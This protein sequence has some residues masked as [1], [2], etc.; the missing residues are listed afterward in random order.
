VM[1]S[2]STYTF[3]LKHIFLIPAVLS[4]SIGLKGYLVENSVEVNG[5]LT[6]LDIYDLA[7]ALCIGLLFLLFWMMIKDHVVAVKL[8]G[9]NITIY[10]GEETITVNW[11]DVDRLSHLVLIQLPVYKL[12]IKNE[13]GYYLF[14]TQPFSINFGFGTIDLS[15]MGREIKK[16]KRELNI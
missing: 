4:I 7:I 8:G 3:L 1:K 13:E 16:K 5:E 12:K 2:N 9:Q 15:D 10:D 14:V 11:F 6:S